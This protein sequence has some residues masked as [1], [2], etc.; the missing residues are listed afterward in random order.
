MSTIFGDPCPILC[1]DF[2]LCCKTSVFLNLHM[3]ECKAWLLCELE[4]KGLI[5]SRKKFLIF[6]SYTLTQEG[7]RTCTFLAERLN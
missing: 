2:L 3:N 4:E 6:H 5:A 7:V 1:H